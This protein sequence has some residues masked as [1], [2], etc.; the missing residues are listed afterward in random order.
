MCADHE[1]GEIACP[2]K[3]N[4]IDLTFDCFGVLCFLNKCDNRATSPGPPLFAYRTLRFINAKVKIR[5]YAY[6]TVNYGDGDT[7]SELNAISQFQA[8][9][10]LGP[11]VK[12]KILSDNPRR[13]YGI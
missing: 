5:P 11:Q 2:D 8:M 12:K 10:G 9:E 3:P 13:F 4:P 7:S 1:C 6:A